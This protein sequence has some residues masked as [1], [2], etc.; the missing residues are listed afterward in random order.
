MQSLALPIWALLIYSKQAVYSKLHNLNP[1]Q[2]TRRHEGTH[3]GAH[4]HRPTNQ[5][6]SHTRNQ[7]TP[8]VTPTLSARA[9]RP[10]G[11]APARAPLTAPPAPQPA[12]P[13]GGAPTCRSR[14]ISS[15]CKRVSPTNCDWR[16]L[17]LAIRGRVCFLSTL[18]IYMSR[19][20][21]GH[22]V[23]H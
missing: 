19:P 8:P 15:S 5:P 22:S 14:P 4:Q 18:S 1:G 10:A 2:D 21:A 6:T 20:Q 12:S 17:A 3:E 23:G 9:R 11:S 16:S 7:P 13:P